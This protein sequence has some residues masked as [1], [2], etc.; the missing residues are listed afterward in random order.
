MDSTH[1]LTTEQAAAYLGIAEQT[2]T[3]WRN[4]R[5]QQIPYLKLGKIVRYRREDLDAWLQSRLVVTDQAA[6]A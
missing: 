5:R 4:N 6:L 2:L 1:T 3:N